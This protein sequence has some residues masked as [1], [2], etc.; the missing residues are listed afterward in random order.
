MSRNRTN[1]RAHTIF[2]FLEENLPPRTPPGLM[3]S[4]DARP[5]GPHK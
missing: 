2:M 3:L 4:P 1:D 5:G